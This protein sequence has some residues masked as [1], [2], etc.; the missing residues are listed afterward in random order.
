LPAPGV[1]VAGPDGGPLVATF[2]APV[3][4]VT[5]SGTG[6]TVTVA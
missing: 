4:T 6:G 5:A 3:T 2:T 1:T